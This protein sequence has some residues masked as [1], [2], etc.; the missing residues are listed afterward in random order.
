MKGDPA[1]EKLMNR[2]PIETYMAL[3]SMDPG[4]NPVIVPWH[5]GLQQA[6]LQCTHLWNVDY[7]NAQGFC[8]LDEGGSK[9]M[10]RYSRSG[11]CG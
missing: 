1:D 6:V 11:S 7:A 4:L 2:L 8:K 3:E 5:Q 9:V 10:S